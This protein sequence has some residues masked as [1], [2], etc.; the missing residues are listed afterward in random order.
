MYT[1]VKTLEHSLRYWSQYV[2]ERN[3]LVAFPLVV[4]TYKIPSMSNA[5]LST[6]FSIESWTQIR[7][8]HQW[9]LVL[10]TLSVKLKTEKDNSKLVVYNSLNIKGSNEEIYW[11]IASRWWKGKKLAQTLIKKELPAF[12]SHSTWTTEPPFWTPQTQQ[13]LTSL[14]LKLLV[15]GL[16]TVCDAHENGK[17]CWKMSSFETK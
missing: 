7:W 1:L 11:Y 12:Q 10:W 4:K 6:E 8:S 16:P 5:I 3:R 17:S 2:F 13:T 14:S 15:H 9:N